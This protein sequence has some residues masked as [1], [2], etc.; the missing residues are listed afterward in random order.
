MKSSSYVVWVTVPLPLLFIFVLVMR[1]LTLE[2]ADEGIRMYLMGIVYNEEKKA[3]ESPDIVEKLTTAGIWTEA[4]SQIFFSIGVCMG[5]MT[6]YSSYNPVD[7]P[8]IGDSLRVSIGNSLV[9]FTAGFAVFSVVG[10]LR[11]INSPV[12]GSVSSIGLAFTAYPAAIERMPAPNLW[13]FLFSITLFTLGLDSAFS[14]VEATSTVITDTAWGR[15]T[16]RKLI[17]LLLCVVGLL[18]STLFCFNWGFTFF[19][20]IDH[21]LANYLMLLLGLL[22]CLGAGWVYEAGYVMEKAN[23]RSVLILAIGFWGVMIPL[24]ILAYTAFP[25]YS[26][27]S[28]P[29]FWVLAFFVFVAS[30]ATSG[31]SLKEWYGTVFMYGVRKLS[32]SMVKLTKEP[33]TH[34]WWAGPFEF[35]WGFSIKYFIPWSLYWLILILTRV[36]LT[37]AYGGYHPFWQVMG[38]MF[39]ILGLILFFVP[40]A[41]CT[42]VEPFDHD[43]D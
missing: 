11:G 27:V 32:R 3:F 28:I 2:N 35:W 15:K 23:K 33:G 21:Y 25:N 26:W 12:S 6:S 16:P 8:I 1:G 43:I 17:A 37:S 7:K 29:I 38:F 30:F 14:L 24:G 41:F 13:A 10:Y 18:F 20:V 40:L 36:D 22:Q 9:S 19:D 42:T 31:L 34:P 4:C 5:V 39:P